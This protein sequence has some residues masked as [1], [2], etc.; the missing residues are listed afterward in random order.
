MKQ[1]DIG[2]AVKKLK[3][4]YDFVK[5]SA[6]PIDP[7][8][9]PLIYGKKNWDIYSDIG[10]YPLVGKY[11]WQIIKSHGKIYVRFCKR[12]GKKVS[13]IYLPRVIMGLQD[14]KTGDTLPGK[15]E[16]IVELI[17]QHEKIVDL[18]KTNLRLTTRTF[19]AY[20]REAARENYGISRTPN[21]SFRARLYFP[22]YKLPLYIKGSYASSWEAWEA[23]DN[24]IRKHELEHII[25][26]SGIEILHLVD[27]GKEY[28]VLSWR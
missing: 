5:F 11:D 27:E 14:I 15:E 28:T 13:M 4:M 20:R 24:F 17:E 26:L 25:P 16:L 1:S 21:G 8:E 12:I 23:R 9:P 22:G 10:D 19:Q 6:N 2:N 7:D 3:E 18:R